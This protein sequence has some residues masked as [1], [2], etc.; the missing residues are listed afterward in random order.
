MELMYILSD[1]LISVVEFL[2]CV[3]I[4]LNE[5]TSYSEN[6]AYSYLSCCVFHAL[7]SLRTERLAL[8]LEI[9]F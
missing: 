4:Y 5:G 7:F 3:V 9:P 2:L 6:C 8:T 1:F